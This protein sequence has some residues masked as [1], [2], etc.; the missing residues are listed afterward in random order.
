V[1]L[2]HGW[3]FFFARQAQL[4]S[5]STAVQGVERTMR[6]IATLNQLF[7]AAVLSQVLFVL[8]VLAFWLLLASRRSVHFHFCLNSWSGP[9]EPAGGQHRNGL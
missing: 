5:M 3:E 7:S 6:E 4:Q 8:P 9:H 1:V 2:P